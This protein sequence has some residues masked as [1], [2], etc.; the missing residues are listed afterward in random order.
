MD[1]AQ[2]VP[3]TWHQLMSSALR[4]AGV[5]WWYR[6]GCEGIRAASCQKEEGP[7]LEAKSALRVEEVKYSQ[8]RPRESAL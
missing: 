4:D 5:L 8:T 2:V 3:D 1:R 7:R 6:R